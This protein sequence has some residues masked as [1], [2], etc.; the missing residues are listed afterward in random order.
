MRQKEADLMR[1]R[2]HIAELKTEREGIIKREPEV[3]RLLDEAGER[4]RALMMPGASARADNAQS[5]GEGLT[6]SDINTN[7]E[8]TV[9]AARTLLDQFRDGPGTPGERGLESLGTTPIRQVQ[10]E[11]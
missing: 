4:Y 1:M 7:G 11:L 8:S 9:T 2:A 6:G 3:Q 5:N 10:M